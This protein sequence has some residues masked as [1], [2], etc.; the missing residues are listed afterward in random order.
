MKKKCIDIH[1]PKYM[2][3]IIGIMIKKLRS[4]KKKQM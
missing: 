3:E 4:I 1:V 2:S